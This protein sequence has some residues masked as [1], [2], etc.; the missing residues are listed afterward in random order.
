MTID[1]NSEES[2]SSVKIKKFIN[3]IYFTVL[4][5]LFS[6]MAC[7]FVPATYK[8]D[9]KSF[10]LVHENKIKKA[11][12]VLLVIDNSSLFSTKRKVYALEKKSEDWKMAFEPFD[13]VIGK[14]GFAP[15]GKKKRG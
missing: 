5:V 14:N 6:L 1:I 4:L 8:F 2:N 12:Q 7:V 13:A 3:L 15:A 10:L 11:T 9:L